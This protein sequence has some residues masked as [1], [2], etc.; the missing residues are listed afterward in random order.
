MDE[1]AEDPTTGICEEL[2]GK[3]QGKVEIG[4]SHDVR[5]HDGTLHD[6]DHLFDVT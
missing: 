3:I 6:R 2:A 5:L 4:F 1:L